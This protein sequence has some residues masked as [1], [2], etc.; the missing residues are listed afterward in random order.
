MRTPPHTHTQIIK[1]TLIDPE[2]YL[3]IKIK[4]FQTTT[5]F[6]F[7]TEDKMSSHVR[8]QGGSSCLA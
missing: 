8:G 2:Y 5:P 4:W 3:E 7:T 1:K 6:E